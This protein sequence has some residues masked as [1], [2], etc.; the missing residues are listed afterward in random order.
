[1]QYVKVPDDKTSSDCKNILNRISKDTEAT[2]NIKEEN[3]NIE[4]QHN[5][6]IKELDISKVLKAIS[7]GFSYDKA[8]EIFRD[9]LVR[10]EVIDIKK[11]TR[12]YKEFKRQ[13]GRIIGENG[14]SKRVISE[15]TDAQIQVHRDKVGIIG[16]T[17]DTLK[18]REAIMRILDG[19]PHA[20]VYSSLEKYQRKKNKKVI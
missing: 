2:V 3:Q 11:S 1:M 8:M 14:K 4:I 12:N 16:D 7:I 9:P 17:N 20:H 13:K 18:A 15:L 6:S 10:F 5:D 19:S